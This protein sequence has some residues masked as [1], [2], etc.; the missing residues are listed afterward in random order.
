[1]AMNKIYIGI[2]NGVS[3]SIGIITPKTSLFFKMPTI[4]Q[5]DY[6]KAKHGITRI[7]TLELKG[8]LEEYIPNGIQGNLVCVGM[9]NP[10]VNPFRWK[11]SA[12]A[13]R[14]FEATLTIV[15]SFQV[16]YHHILAKDWQKD[17]FGKGYEGDAKKKVKVDTKA[18]SLQKAKQFFPKANLGKHPDGDGLLLAYYMKKNNF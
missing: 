12:S 10:M 7:D 18:I 11:A 16:P 4:K 14:A 13:L 6:H 17:I 8:L 15:E 1:M 3:G 5:Q 9:E 2:D